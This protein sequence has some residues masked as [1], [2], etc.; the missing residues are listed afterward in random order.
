MFDSGTAVWNLA[1]VIAAEFFL[2]LE[3]KWAMVGRDH[4][5]VISTQSFPELLLIR[6]VAQRRRHDI[7]RALETFLFVIAVVQEKIL[8][9]RLGKRRQAK[10]ARGLHFFEGVVATQVHDVDRRV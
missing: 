7:L 8:R 9:A 3:T 6:L 5:Q 1:E 4:L 10:V 2:F